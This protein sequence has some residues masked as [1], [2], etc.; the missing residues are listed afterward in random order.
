MT[1]EDFVTTQIPY[2]KQLLMAL[3]DTGNEDVAIWVYALIRQRYY[4]HPDLPFQIDDDLCHQI[5]QEW[6]IWVEKFYDDWGTRE[7]IHVC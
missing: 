7:F 2:Y 6:A 5:E 1:K 4:C 3:S